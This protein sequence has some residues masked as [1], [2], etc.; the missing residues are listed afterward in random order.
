MIYNATLLRLDPPPPGLPGAD[1]DV[2]GAVAPL[3]AL[4]AQVS[5][6]EHW[7]ATAIFYIPAR[8][9]PSPGPIVGGY[10]LLRADGAAD[11]AL[12]PIVQVIR[13]LGRTLSHTQVWLGDPV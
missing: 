13:R 8:T 12:R 11:A 1:T 3:T 9:A 2:R 4:Q 7:G 6:E 5:S 10:A